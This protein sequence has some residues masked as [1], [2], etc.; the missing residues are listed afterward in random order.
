MDMEELTAT[1]QL[2]GNDMLETYARLELRARI[3]LL[4][5]TPIC[6]SSLTRNALRKSQLT[7]LLRSRRRELSRLDQELA[8]ID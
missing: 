2:P 8:L 7:L 5:D 6:D 3:P 1:A 4:R